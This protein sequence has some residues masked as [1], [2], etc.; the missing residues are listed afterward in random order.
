MNM[1]KYELLYG[2]YGYDITHHSW[3]ETRQCARNYIKWFR[4]NDPKAETKFKIIKW[5][6]R[7]I[8]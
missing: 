5:A 4:K 7:Y 6:G 2:G 1:I 8:H 3:H